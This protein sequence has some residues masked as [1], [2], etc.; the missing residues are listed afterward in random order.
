MSCSTHL[1]RCP[2]WSVL[3]VCLLGLQWCPQPAASQTSE[4][5][6][7]AQAAETTSP[8]LLAVQ[9]V[10][11][12]LVAAYNAGKAD[13]VAACF[14]PGGE[15][16][17]D[18]GNVY[19]GQDAIAAAFKAYRERFPTA[20][21]QLTVESI[22]LAADDVAV[23]NGVRVVTT[24]D[25]TAVNRYTMTYVKRDGKWL[26]ASARE[27]SADPEPTPHERLLPLEWLVGEWVEESSETAIRLLCRWAP[28][29]NF[30]LVEF[31]AQVDGA[32]VMQSHQRIGWDPH[33]ERI[34]S[35]VFDSDGGYGEGRWAQ[36]DG[37]WV[38]KSTATMPDGES[39]SATLYI[40]PVDDNKFIMKGFE[41]VAGDSALPDFEAVIVRKPPSPAKN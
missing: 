23:E 3:A 30:L 8:D 19:A 29:E 35:W 24:D 32:V 20:R 26:V 41:R 4:P 38:I 1:L 36:V 11:E 28:N 9:A 2:I 16:V 25:A 17:D 31:T 10:S 21:M 37:A 5:A 15:V 6:D 14:L 33:A 40:E 7:A 13:E 12:A 22:R 39:G 34:R 18:A 27:V